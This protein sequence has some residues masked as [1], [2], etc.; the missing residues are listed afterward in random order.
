MSTDLRHHSYSQNMRRFPAAGYPESVLR[1]YRSS[2]GELLGICRSLDYYCSRPKSTNVGFSRNRK[3]KKKIGNTKQPR[4]CGIA[5][6]Q[7][8]FRLPRMGP[9]PGKL[10][11]PR[12]RSGANPNQAGAN[13]CDLFGKSQG[14]TPAY[15]ILSSTGCLQ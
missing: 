12:H 6:Q 15:T 1:R 8:R 10:K 13:P 9:L 3:P 5:G 4:S 2:V 11:A 14:L 7:L